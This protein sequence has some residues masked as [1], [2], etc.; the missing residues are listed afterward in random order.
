MVDT[1]PSP[2]HNTNPNPNH[3]TNPNPNPNPILINP[4][5][6]FFKKKD[7]PRHRPRLRPQPC[8]ILPPN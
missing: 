5:K 8:V 4:K 2:N 3:N 6:A 7:K 1:N